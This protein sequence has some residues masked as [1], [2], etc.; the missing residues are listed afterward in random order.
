MYAWGDGTSNDVIPDNVSA[1]GTSATIDHSFQ[2]SA[3]NKTVTLTANG[4]PGTLVQNGRTSTVTMQLHDVPAAPTAITAVNLSMNTSSQGTSPYLCAG[5][6]R[7]ESGVG[8][9]TGSSVIRY[10]TTTPIR[11]N[12]LTDINGSHTGTLS[13]QLNGADIGSKAFTTATGESGT[14]D[15]LHISSEGDAHDEISASTYP[16]RF[17][18][19]F[20]AR[21]D[22][23]LSQ[24]PTGLSDYGMVHSTL[25]SAG[26]TT[27]V[28]DDLNTTPT[29]SAG[30]LSESSGGT[31]RY[32]SGIPYY[33]SGWS[34]T[35]FEWSTGN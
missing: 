29:T 16:S 21:V 1:G 9:N 35:Y 24:I 15:D 33:D 7:N 32:I 25:G 4:T 11:T 20:T 19:V 2:G 26:I 14:F 34:N 3:G 13:A 23:P 22:Q 28:K 8:I 10:A 6:T 5:A 27:F 30:T 18:Q 12:Y 31:K 17:Y